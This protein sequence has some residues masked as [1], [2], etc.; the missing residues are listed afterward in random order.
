M[1]Q[2]LVDPVW[3]FWGSVIP[4]NCGKQIFLLVL[5]WKAWCHFK[6]MLIR[7]G[8]PSRTLVISI[9]PRNELQYLPSK[10]WGR[11]RSTCNN[12]AYDLFKCWH[13]PVST[14]CNL[15]EVTWL[16]KSEVQQNVLSYRG[17]GGG[18]LRQPNLKSTKMI[19]SRRRGWT[20][21]LLVSIWR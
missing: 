17:Y 11:R 10:M 15:E 9:S 4:S 6:P 1:N 21:R 14:R 3:H 18:G 2:T 7:F 19:N 12:P 5:K 16:T 20:G 8:S 13:V